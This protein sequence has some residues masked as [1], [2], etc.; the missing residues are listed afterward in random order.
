VPRKGLDP[1]QVTDAAV[2]IADAEGLEAVTIAR[3]AADLGVRAPS[4]YNHVAGRKALLDAISARAYAEA[5][6]KLQAATVG[7]AGP[8][9]VRALAQAL[10]EYALAAPG[11]YAATQR[12]PALGATDAAGAL[13]DVII[14]A[15]R[16]WELQGDEE[17]HAVRAL[18]SAV[19]GFVTIELA[20]G[21]QIALDRDASYARLVEIVISGLGPPAS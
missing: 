8:D 13:V 17:V 4:L 1:Q 18:R 5:T 10:R 21:F 9:A 3:V 12:A 19:H 20:G 6:A 11:R 7:R 2:A 16:A 15:L 14:G